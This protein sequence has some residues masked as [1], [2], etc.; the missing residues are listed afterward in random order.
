MEIG[1]SFA[2]ELFSSFPCVSLEG[3]L[4]YFCTLVRTRF[5]L[6]GSV[7]ELVASRFVRSQDQ[8]RN[9]RCLSRSSHS[10]HRFLIHFTPVKF[11]FLL[12]RE[13]KESI[14]SSK[15]FGG[16]LAA[17]SIVACLEIEDALTMHRHNS[18]KMQGRTFL[19]FL[20][21]FSF[22]RQFSSRCVLFILG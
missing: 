18:R 8:F 17:G 15:F 19:F 4:A 5:T 6:E 7:G 2:C 12:L 22:S 10:I 13:K 9:T 3:L 16:N 20:S 14:A 1:S 11:A 21:F